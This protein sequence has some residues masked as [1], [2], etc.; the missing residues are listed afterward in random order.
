MGRVEPLIVR[1]RG[2]SVRG[3][4]APTEY[5][6]Y[7]KLVYYDA[8]RQR[9]GLSALDVH[10]GQSAKWWKPTSGHY[11]LR[12]SPAF[13]SHRGLHTSYRRA[14]YSELQLRS[15]PACPC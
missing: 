2:H 4:S 8:S 5:R 11:G 3:I 1:L 7:E 14:A 10:A 12:S 9:F 15:R 13:R 6:N